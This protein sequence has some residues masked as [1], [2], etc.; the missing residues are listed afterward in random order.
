MGESALIN[1]LCLVW[2]HF[3]SDF[4][5]QTDKMA[6]NKSKSNIWLLTH[7]VTYS[8]PMLFFA[9][10]IFAVING[11]AHFVVDWCTSRVNSR[12]WKSDKR[13][14]FFTMI[15]FDQAI[16]LTTLAVVYAAL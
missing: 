13:H 11:A 1:F 3:I 7:A 9:G 16:H 2:L 8:L 5:L 4:I 14:L 10:P 6:L 15:G 12:L